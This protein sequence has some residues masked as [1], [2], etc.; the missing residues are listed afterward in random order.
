[1]AMRIELDDVTRPEVLE[2]LRE[3]LA[4]MHELT[5]PEQVF[6]FDASKLRAPGVTFWSVWDGAELVGC[7]ALKELDAQHGEVKS[8]RTPERARRRGAGKAVLEQIIATARS[9]GYRRLSLETG[10]HP[11]FSPAHRLYERYGFV[12]CGAF[13]SY[14]ENPHSVFMT[15]GLDSAAR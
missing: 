5:P 9:R 12:R 7:G 3:H 4:N 11:A 1:M 2:L 6:A 14:V 8:M 13:G 15:L 10:T